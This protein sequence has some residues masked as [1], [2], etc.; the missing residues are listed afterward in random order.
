[1]Q[2]INKSIGGLGAICSRERFDDS[3]ESNF[4]HRRHFGCRLYTEKE[5]KKNEQ[6]ERGRRKK[7]SKKVQLSQEILE[8]KA[9]KAQ[10]N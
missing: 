10:E 8:R 7:E 6:S 2:K 9:G 3:V 4:L 1:M 5:K